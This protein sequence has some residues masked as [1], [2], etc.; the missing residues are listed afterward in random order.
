M[1]AG[2]KPGQRD[3]V[4]TRTQ[5]HPA[6]SLYRDGW[7]TQQ[8]A[9]WLGVSRQAIWRMLK[10]RGIPT[11]PRHI[12]RFDA[13]GGFARNNAD[14]APREE[15]DSAGCIVTLADLVSG[16][17]H[18]MHVPGMRRDALRFVVRW[19]DLAPGDWRVLCYST[20]ST[21]LADLTGA[22]ASLGNGPHHASGITVAPEV[23]VLGSIGRL[24]LL[25]PSLD[26]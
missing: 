1:K 3:G 22:R 26:R 9:D 4:L 6:C 8:L 19:C 7:N 25:H 14:G 17:T 21:I 2:L 15:R 23:V 20:P 18:T 5:I 10:R 24:D 13:D 12:K 16:Q 11:R